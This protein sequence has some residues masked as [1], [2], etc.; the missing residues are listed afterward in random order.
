MFQRVL[1]CTDLEDGLQ[2]LIHFVPSLAMSG[3][4]QIVFLHTLPLSEDREI[5][6]L[7]PAQEA[8]I[9]QRLSPAIAHIPEGV[10]VHI[11]VRTGRPADHILSAIDAYGSDLLVL[12]TPSRSR[13][14]ETLFGSTTMELCKRLTIPLM[15]LRPQLISTYTTEEL[16]L[17][18][19]HLF[20]SF[21]VPYDGSYA[22]NYLISA[23]KAHAKARSPES[24]K[25]C[26]LIWVVDGVGRKGLQDVRDFQ[27]REAE[28]AIATVKAD[29]EDLDLKVDALVRR[30][31][32]ISEVIETALEYDVSAIAIASDSLGNFLEWSI[33]SFA[34]EVL[35]RSWHPVIYFP[36]PR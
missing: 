17:R 13:L 1:I 15:I 28:E 30:G 21:L 36:V 3:L 25:E 4:Q 9:K 23:I 20:R 2:R 10:T 31:T 29:L 34:G 11:D 22:A 5:P 33:P 7:N 14:T 32:A 24:L 27:L 16:S 19:Q 12:G 8:A 35:R 6:R 26:L 18:C